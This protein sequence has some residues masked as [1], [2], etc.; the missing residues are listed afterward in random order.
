MDRLKQIWTGK[1]RKWAWPTVCGTLA[2]AWLVTLWT[3]ANL[4][5]RNRLL[6]RVATIQEEWCDGLGRVNE[7]CEATLTEM[8]I[9]LG[10]DADYHPLVT[11]ALWQRAMRHTSVRQAR[12]G[13]GAPNVS[14]GALGDPR[15]AMGGP[16]E[17]EEAAIEKAAKGKS[18][19]R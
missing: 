15:S 2:L 17:D 11:T 7:V 19:K 10:L 18:W 14:R 3:N 4:R 16:S 5:E 9:R 12:R 6:G 8:A 1:W 13:L